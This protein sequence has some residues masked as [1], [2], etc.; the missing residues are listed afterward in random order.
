MKPRRK[1]ILTFFV[2]FMSIFLFSKSKKTYYILFDN[3]K[4]ETAANA[5][6]V[7]DDNQP[8]PDPANPTSESDWIGGISSWGYSLYATGN[9]V[10]KTLTS[11][12]GITYNDSNNPY[13]LSNFDVFVLCEPN[14][15]FTQSEKEAIIQFVNNGGGLFLIADHNGS[16]RDGDGWDSPHVLND[17]FDNN[18]YVTNIFGVEYELNSISGDYSNTKTSQ[19]GDDTELLNGDFGS[20]STISYHGGSSMSIDTSAN[21]NATALIWENGVSQDSTTSVVAAYSKYGS[22]RIFF[23]GDSSPADDGTGHPGDNLQDGWNENDDGKLILNATKW[24][25]EASGTGGDLPPS[26][27][28]I[29]QSPFFPTSSDEVTVSADVNDDVGLV[30]VELFYSLDGGNYS[31]IDMTQVKSYNA[32]IPS[33]PDGT[34]VEYYIKA[35]DTS[36]NTTLSS[37]NGYFSGTT[38]IRK[39]RSNDENGGN[40]Y[41]GYHVRVQGYI[42]VSTGTFNTS[43]NDIYVEDYSSGV[44]IWQHNSQSPSVNVGDEV[45]V[46]AIINQY[47]GKTEL[48]ISNS[49]SNMQVLSTSN[50][51]YPTILPTC[52]DINE[53]HEGMLVEIRNVRITDGS[54]PSSGSNAWN[55]KIEDKYGNEGYMAVDKDTNIDGTPTPTGEFNLIGVVYQYDNSSPYNSGYKI[56][57]R[58]LDD[59]EENPPEIP[60]MVINE[61]CIHPEN[62]CDTNEDGYI[63]HTE[64][65]F[66]EILNCEKEDID[67][68]GWKLYLNSTELYE[69]PNSTQIYGKESVTIFG[70]GTPSGDYGDYSIELIASGGLNLPDSGNLILKDSSGNTVCSVYYNSDPNYSGSYTRY[71]DIT[72]LFTKHIEAGDGSCSSAGFRTNGNYFVSNGDID[73]DGEISLNDLMLLANFIVGNIDGNSPLIKSTNHSLDVN[74]DGTINSEDS[75]LLANLL[76]GN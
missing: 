53:L 26:I 43:S 38:P 7:I 13:D 23:L 14:N 54:F 62:S 74:V 2:I 32:T 58:S 15:P 9:Y 31:S 21:S 4:S 49:P 28:N 29:S 59:I 73:Y 44:N 75:L 76:A 56:L 45:K 30:S 65:Q 71:P 60:N 8:D 47:N 61:Y 57:P 64:D 69:F 46:E 35:V 39:I 27:T 11:D 52:S 70:G 6:W 20:V 36:G 12:Y 72:G 19:N 48:D 67:I 40:L 51:I 68:S 33:Q 63:D 5:D 18:G 41:K 10:V 37:L 3:T 24:L 22:G 55:I 16:D 1:L 50:D 66:I 25:A 34:L 17:L 42:T